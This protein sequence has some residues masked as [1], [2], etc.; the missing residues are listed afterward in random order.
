MCNLR[1]L[2][3]SLAS[4]VSSR[5]AIQFEV[6]FVLPVNWKYEWRSSHPNHELNGNLMA[7]RGTVNFGAAGVRVSGNLNGAALQVLHLDGSR[8]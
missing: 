1:P 4:L 2:C 8:M 3:I 7:P 5:G 6:F